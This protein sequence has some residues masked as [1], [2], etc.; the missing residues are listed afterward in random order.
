MVD[1]ILIVEDDRVQQRMIV[2][3]LTKKL[4]YQALTASNGKDALAKI[5]ESNVGDINAVLLDIQM[6]E[7]D[8]FETLQ[9]IRKYRPDLP[10]IM[11]T[12]SDN[13]GIA[14]KAIKEGASDFIVKPPD[15]AHLDVAIKNA[16]R[17]S[18]LSRELTKMKRDKEGA[19]SFNDLVGCNSGLANAVALGRKAA[20]SAVPVLIT[21]ESGVGKELFARAIHGESKRVGSPFV[22]VNCSAIPEHLIEGTLFSPEKGAFRKAENGTVFLD[23]IDKLPHEAQVR[24]LRL[25][26]HKEIESVN[27]AKP[28]KVNVRIIAASERDLA[29]DIQGG[30]FREDLY[31][32]LNILPIALPSLRER[33]QD[34][35]PIAEYFIE[36]LA[37]SE[38]LLSKKLNKMAKN[39]LINQ[40]WS[41]NVRE[42]ENLIHRALVVADDEDIDE[43]VLQQIHQASSAPQIIERRTTPALHINMRLPDGRFKTIDEIEVEALRNA[44][45]HFENNITHAADAVGMAKS[46]FYRKIKD[47]P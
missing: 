23:D 17:L 36:R 30:K 26:Q 10:V 1:T 4:G 27:I 40:Y 3:L 6:P 25:L 38:G 39:Y 16:M 46:T 19:L 14:V 7:M 20:A 15:P 42:L 35:I 33:K 32:R 18:T 44:L 29:R 37:V 28:I 9:A 5:Q 41:G 45:A 21:G 13:T 31:F 22:A 2:T 24:L 43:V 8:G 47:A 34:I 12:G 11:L